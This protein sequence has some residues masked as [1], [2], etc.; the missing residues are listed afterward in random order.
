MSDLNECCL[1]AEKYMRLPTDTARQLYL[2]T[3]WVGAFRCAPSF[4]IRRSDWDSCLLLY[5][6]S[7]MGTL[8]TGGQTYDVPPGSVLLLDC[9][10]P[11]EYFPAQAPWHFLF[12]HFSGPGAAAYTAYLNRICGGPVW[13]CGAA[14]C[15]SLIRRVQT[16]TQTH[17]SEALTDQLLHRLLD[18]LIM[19]QETAEPNRVQCVMDYIAA[20]Y[21]EPL[22]VQSLAQHFHYSRAWFSTWFQSAA[23]VSPYAYLL[24]CRLEAARQQLLHT[25]ASVRAIAEQCGFASDSAMIRAFK[26]K[27]GKTPLE[28]RKRKDVHSV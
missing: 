14:D 25:D 2:Y 17:G 18:T 4:R 16:N 9:R 22:I 3:E 8:R 13:P 11:H 6:L 15:E 24:R 20:H 21:M 12:L 27:T 7:G 19:A 10:A 1:S 26:A 23:G 28:Y 5:T